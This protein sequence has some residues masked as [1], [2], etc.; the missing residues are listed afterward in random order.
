LAD[1]P[2]LEDIARCEIS[3]P[4]SLVF[5]SAATIWE[6]AIK[7]T[8]GR[9]DSGDTDL[10][11]EIGKNGFMELAINARHVGRGE[12]PTAEKAHH[13]TATKN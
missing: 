1:D 13:I 11:E 8:L 7:A 4:E 12:I 6:L 3:K 5:I 9:L 2:R 10:V